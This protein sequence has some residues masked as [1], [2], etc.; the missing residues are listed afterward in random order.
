MTIG[1]IYQFSD[2]SFHQVRIRE[3]LNKYLKDAEAVINQAEKICVRWTVKKK[4]I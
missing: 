3:A 1:Y 2:G 4:A